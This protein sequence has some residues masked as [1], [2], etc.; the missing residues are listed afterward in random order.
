MNVVQNI[1]DSAIDSNKVVMFSK[2]YCPYCHAAKA[3]L[4]SKGIPVQVLE[5]DQRPDGD[6]IQSYLK[7]KSGQRTVPNIFV[8]KKHIGGSSDLDLASKDGT[9][10]SLLK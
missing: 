4:K 5:L 2:S 3:L 6:Q 1:V 8:M 9:L 7:D 10:D